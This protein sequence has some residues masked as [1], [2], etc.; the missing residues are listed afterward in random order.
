MNIKKAL[1]SMLVLA[2]VV[3]NLFSV[4][5]VAEAS[6]GFHAY[7]TL[8]KTANATQNINSLHYN[9]TAN[10]TGG[11]N[12]LES[13][14]GVWAYGDINQSDFSVNL[15][16]T[17]TDNP[18]DG[19]ADISYLDIDNTGYLNINH[20]IPP[21]LAAFLPAAPEG[22]WLVM[23]DPQINEI[24]AGYED[25]LTLQN[26]SLTYSQIFSELVLNNVIVFDGYEFGPVMEGQKTYVMP[27]HVDLDELAEYIKRDPLKFLT[28]EESEEFI[29]VLKMIDE[30]IK[31][32]GEIYVSTFDFL[33]RLITLNVQ[34]QT[35][36]ANRVNLTLELS[37]YN[38][39]DEL[40]VPEKVITMKEYIQIIDDHH[41]EFHD[42]LGNYDS[43]RIDDHQNDYCY[44]DYDND[45][46]DN[47]QELIYRTDEYNS[48]T[49]GDG[50]PD[51][52]E[53]A[54]GYSP[55]GHGRM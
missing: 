38:W 7:R 18:A 55:I 19:C 22:Q 47:C 16:F 23:D 28:N 48:D 54:N 3:T 30:Q 50:Y 13:T 17:T 15:E 1:I 12:D 21:M 41:C 53:V 46:L 43:Y 4:A 29:D 6:A 9:L 20:P 36:T 27:Y 52:L 40:T 34:D 11:Y 45:G 31:L 42:D 39:A 37:Q 32:T 25:F 24:R 14:T 49:D 26:E 33:P 5:Q 44:Q 8:M 35:N 10:Y 2:V 51:G